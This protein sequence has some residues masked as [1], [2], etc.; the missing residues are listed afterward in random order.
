MGPKNSTPEKF[1][2]PYLRCFLEEEEDGLR[3]CEEQRLVK[4]WVE[5]YQEEGQVWKSH[6]GGVLFTYLFISR[7]LSCGPSVSKALTAQAMQA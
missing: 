1:K 7:D 4:N 2:W 6:E 3:Q 5:M